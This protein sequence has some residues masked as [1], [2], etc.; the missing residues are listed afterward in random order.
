[1]AAAARGRP[2]EA[3]LPQKARLGLS[4]RAAARRRTEGWNWRGRGPRTSGGWAGN[5]AEGLEVA[6][7]VSGGASR[8]AGPGKELQSLVRGSPGRGEG[9][10]ESA[11]AWA[12][13]PGE[14]EAGVRSRLWSPRC[15][16]FALPRFPRQG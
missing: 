13:A 10:C 11:G 5:G 16:T 12:A 9:W 6:G 14:A 3:G 1:M 7:A 2:E 8:P 15:L 4:G